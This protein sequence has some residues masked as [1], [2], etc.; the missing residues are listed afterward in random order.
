MDVLAIIHKKRLLTLYKFYFRSPGLVK[1]QRNYKPN[2]IL[3]AESFNIIAEELLD[4][5]NS[6]AYIFVN[7]QGLRLTDFIE[8]GESFKFLQKYIKHS[9]SALKFERVSRLPKDAYARLI[10]HVKEEC[11]VEE[12]VKLNG[13]HVGEFEPYYDI[14]SRIIEINFPQLSDDADER[15]EDLEE[16]DQYLRTIL[17]QLPS[18]DHSLIFTTLTYST[19]PDEERNQTYEIFEEIFNAKGDEELNNKI[20]DI[21]KVKINPHVKHDGM[22]TKYVSAFDSDFLDDNMELIQIIGTALIGYLGYQAYC[23]LTCVDTPR[24]SQKVAT[25][26][27]SSGRETETDRQAGCDSSSNIDAFNIEAPKSDVVG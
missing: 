4:N 24:K 15:Q 1:Y 11:N 9:S 16:Y 2:S 21:P 27:S 3:P 23:Y 26:K 10:T 13:V 22:T 17:A 6:D 8:Y 7:V 19:V 18:P 5:C 20:L 14:K 12:T 25:N